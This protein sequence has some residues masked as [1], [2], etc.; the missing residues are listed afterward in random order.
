VKNAA[1]TLTIALGLAAL[2]PGAGA[3]PIESIENGGFESSIWN[4]W[5]CTVTPGFGGCTT[6][7]PTPH[8]GDAAFAGYD[9]SVFGYG[10]LS[11][12]VA[13]FEGRTYEFSFYSQFLAYENPVPPVVVNLWYSL[14]GGDWVSVAPT[15]GFALTTDTFTSS[16]S[17]WAEIAFYFQATYG[18]GI[19]GIDDVAI[20]PEFVDVPESS[21]LSL[22]G[23]GLLGVAVLWRRRRA[24]ACSVAWPSSAATSF[25]L[26]L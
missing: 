7:F 22:L 23:T 20:T 10:T 19:W 4:P 6:S 11:Q 17:H 26:R 2:P 15:S 24:N 5:V 12:L 3:L 14:D 16:S 18:S 9:A 13:V 8:T 25:G 21:A 1:G